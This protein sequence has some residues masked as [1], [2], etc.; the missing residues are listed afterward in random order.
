MAFD[1]DASPGPAKR[2]KHSTKPL[3]ERASRSQAWSDPA[4]LIA[5][6]TPTTPFPFEQLGEVMK[7]AV[8]AIAEAVQVPPEMAA[9]SVLAVAALGVQGHYD[10]HHPATGSTPCSLMFLT[11]AESSAR[12]SSSDKI[13]TKF[14]DARLE[15]DR[16]EYRRD[17]AR[18]KNRCEALELQR[19]T[20]RKKARAKNPP[21]A[22]QIETELN[23]IGED[24]EQPLDPKRTFTEANAEGLLKFM[25]HAEGSLAWLNN[26]AGQVIAGTGFSEDNK[27]KFC[28]TLNAFW[29]GQTVDRLR[30]GDGVR[31]VRRRRL[32]THLMAQPKIANRF[33]SDPYL[34]DA[35]FFSRCLIVKPP[36]LIGQREFRAV[37]REALARRLQPFETKVTELIRRAPRV[38]A[39]ANELDPNV[40]PWSKDAELLWVDFYNDTEKSMAPGGIHAP[41]IGFAGK[42]AENI[43]RIATVLQIIEN[44]AAAEVEPRTMFIAVEIGRFYLAEALRLREAAS[45]DNDFAVAEELR[46]WLGRHCNDDFTSARDIQQRGPAAL[47]KDAKLRDRV[48]ALLV[49][50]GWLATPAPAEIEGR[51]RRNAYQLH[52]RIRRGS[53]G[54]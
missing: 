46:L 51:K 31:E 39:R 34:S 49:D 9:Q 35:G 30:S 17:F 22:D 18:W 23:R 14:L 29:D 15:E 45:A 44:E 38:G 20:I 37:D 26:E 8:T 25:E 48:L 32:T 10:A 12:K 36:S 3:S 21:S 47:R 41:L 43:A 1:P 19:D 24:P 28:A 7:A 33:L 16:V 52:P 2:A 13:A 54:R 5:P 42:I 53:L 50:T 11:I 6:E 4:P 40:L 27:I